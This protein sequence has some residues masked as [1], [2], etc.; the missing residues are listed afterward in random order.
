MIPFGS[1]RSL[2]GPKDINCEVDG[3]LMKVGQCV[4]ACAKVTVN[5]E[6]ELS[7]LLDLCVELKLGCVMSLHVFNYGILKEAQARVINV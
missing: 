1:V 3:I 5:M 7:Q 2:D 6:D 4:Y